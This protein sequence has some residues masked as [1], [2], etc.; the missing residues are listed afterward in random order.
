[1]TTTK[2]H[3]PDR[4]SLASS[5]H[6]LSSNGSTEGTRKTTDMTLN[7]CSSKPT[8]R[9]KKS[10]NNAPRYALILPRQMPLPPQQ[11]N[12]HRDTYNRAWETL[13]A[14]YHPKQEEYDK[15]I[16]SLTNC[17]KPK[18]KNI[19]QLGRCNNSISSSRKKISGPGSS[20]SSSEN[21]PIS[22]N[23]RSLLLSSSYA[24][25]RKE[26]RPSSVHGHLGG[27]GHRHGVSKIRRNTDSG[28][29]SGGSS[30]SSTREY[31]AERGRDRADSEVVGILYD[32]RWYTF[33]YS[34]KNTWKEST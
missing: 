1:M 10:N 5:L 8:P 18:R 23:Y 21:T 28:T 11:P 3:L 17:K 24:N 32:E 30:G 29:E 16:S 4:L 33:Y 25:V 13:S 27:S 34:Y 12:F 31:A 6:D 9:K 22:N 20:G 2:N 19:F 15:A 14:T 26:P 7:T